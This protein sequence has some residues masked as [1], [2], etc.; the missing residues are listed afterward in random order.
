MKDSKPDEERS[1]KKKKEMD[2]ITLSDLNS[3]TVRPVS[4]PPPAYQTSPRRSP[5]EVK[6]HIDPFIEHSQQHSS[7]HA[8]FPSQRQMSSA[9]PFRSPIIDTP[10]NTF[11]TAFMSFMVGSVTSGLGGFC[12]LFCFEVNYLKPYCLGTICQ[13]WNLHWIGASISWSW[14]FECISRSLE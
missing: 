6:K 4:M 3:S 13:V 12:F 11:G 5:V 2:E 14:I 8:P 10:Q 7:S 9:R 1:G